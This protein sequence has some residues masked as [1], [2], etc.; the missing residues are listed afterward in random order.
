M[1]SLMY[2]D[3]L[4]R[5]SVEHIALLPGDAPHLRQRPFKPKDAVQVFT[6]RLFDNLLADRLDPFADLVEQ[7]E[8]LIDD[9]IRQRIDQ[10]ADRDRLSG[11][12]ARLAALHHFGDD[13]LSF[14][15]NG[16]D[17]IVPDEDVQFAESRGLLGNPPPGSKSGTGDR[18]IPRSL[19]RWR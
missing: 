2:F 10:E 8:I 17:V 3:L 19:G 7:R 1:S 6:V 18:G 9:R 5:E 15:M 14:A 12:D 4:T 11:F 13:R 16:D